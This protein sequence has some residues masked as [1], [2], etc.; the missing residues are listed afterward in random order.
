MT[1]NRPQSSQPFHALALLGAALAG[2]TAARLP[3]AI[4]TH[5]RLTAATLAPTPTAPAA[6]V[7]MQPI[8]PSSAPAPIIQLQPVYIPV[9]HQ[10]AQPAPQIIHIHHYGEAAAPV[11]PPF[12]TGI[13]PDQRALAESAQPPKPP[14]QA[15]NQPANSPSSPT[16]GLLATA[17][18]ERLQR[19]EKREALRLFEAALA[20]DDTASPDP[21]RAQWQ[22]QAKALKRRWSGEAFTLVRNSPIDPATGFATGPLLGASQSGAALGYTVNPLARRPLTATAR[23]NAATDAAGRTDP[24]TA[25]AAFG[26][27]YQALPTLAISAERLV[28]LGELARDDWLLRLSSGITRQTPIGGQ[29]IRLDAY[30]EINLLGSGD[31]LAAGQARALAPLFGKGNVSLAAGL[32]SWGSIQNTSGSTIGRFDVGPSAAVRLGSGRLA[33]EL[34]ADYR[35]RLAGE[36]LPASGPTLTLSSS[37]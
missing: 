24:R 18:Y 16:P 31:A 36:A 20:S 37:F 30:G 3:A 9:P 21:R 6:Q 34:T 29:R 23:I 13:P 1:T 8:A 22:R 35:Q 15:S 17:A 5:G 7:Q 26:L 12:P 25:Q 33:L 28:S 19:G 4:E 27:R 11:I 14:F 10:G 32:G 2:W